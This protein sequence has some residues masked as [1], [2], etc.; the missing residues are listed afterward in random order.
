MMLVLVVKH[1]NLGDQTLVIW[2]FSQAHK[3]KIRSPFLTI[4]NF[5]FGFLNLDFVWLRW[6]RWIQIPKVPEQAR[7]CCETS[8]WDTSD[9]QVPVKGN[10]ACKSHYCHLRCALP[11]QLGAS[12]SHFGSQLPSNTCMLITVSRAVERNIHWLLSNV[13]YTEG[14]YQHFISSGMA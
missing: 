9:Q 6:R 5:S 13:S 12:L 7:W 14:L 8:C 11:P 1:R 4:C 3:W 10:A 2:L